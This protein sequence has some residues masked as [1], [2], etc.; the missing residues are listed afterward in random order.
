MEPALKIQ[1]HL[2][3]LPNTFLEDRYSGK[4]LSIFNPKR[5]ELFGQLDTWGGGWNPPIL[6]KRIPFQ[7][8]YGHSQSEKKL[9]VD[10]KYHCSIKVQS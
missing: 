7:T 5:H 6:E 1:V 8:Q 9:G 3:S 2:Q 4:R 10:E